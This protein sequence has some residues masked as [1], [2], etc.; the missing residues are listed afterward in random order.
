MGICC[1]LGY[2]AV[3][4]VPRESFSGKISGKIPRKAPELEKSDVRKPL[5]QW[6]SYVTFVV[7]RL[8]RQSSS[9]K[10]FREDFQTDLSLQEYVLQSR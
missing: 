1:I 4:I 3:Q 8:S 6:F 5:S 7:E 2:F 9:L 10:I